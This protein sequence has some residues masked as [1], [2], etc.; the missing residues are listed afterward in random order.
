M[1]PFSYSDYTVS[2]KIG[3]T[4]IDIEH[5]T[6]EVESILDDSFVKICEEDSGSDLSTVKKLVANLYVSK[7]YNW[8]TGATA[9]FFVHLYVGPCGFKQEC[10]PVWYSGFVP[11]KNQSLFVVF[12]A[13][14]YNAS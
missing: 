11:Y 14:Q 9:E 7:N 2:D 1:I 12:Q 5:L 6:G 13:F 10:F 8:I 3:L 4:V